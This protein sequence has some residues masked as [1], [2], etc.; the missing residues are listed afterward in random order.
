M[1]PVPAIIESEHAPAFA[2]VRAAFSAYREAEVQAEK[3]EKRA[4]SARGAREMRKRELALALVEVRKLIPERGPK[5]KAWGEFCEQEG[6]SQSWAWKLME[7]VGYRSGGSEP[8]FHSSAANRNET[9]DLPDAPHPAEAG[10]LT[11]GVVPPSPRKPLGLLSD[12]QLLVG[13]WQDVLSPDEIGMVDTIITDPP[14]SERTHKSTPTRNDGSEADGLKPNYPPWGQDDVEAFVDAWSPRCR[15][16]MV[17]LCDHTMIPWYEDA[18]ARNGRFVFAPVPCIIRGMSVRT[19]GDGPSSE[20]V[21]AMVARPRTAESASWG[22]VQGYH[23]G[24]KEPGAKHG[25]GKPRWLL[26]EL[27]RDYSRENDLVCDPLAGYGVTLVSA[28]LQ[29]RR[30]IGAE[31]DA[32]AVEE[33]FRRVQLINEPEG[34][35]SA[36]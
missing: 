11:T 21:Y 30:A 26:D 36:P 17:C 3:A 2:A 13:R 29:R 34:A 19:R 25:R 22:T 33:G 14:F 5:A 32:A 15:G 12:M 9:S 6:I 18:Y 16:W 28:I 7:W 24:A 4:E 8:G 10:E 1:K 27:V 23:F 31:M 20:V 35:A